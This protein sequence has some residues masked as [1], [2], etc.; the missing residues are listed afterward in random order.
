MMW[1]RIRPGAFWER[2]IENPTINH[3]LREGWRQLVRVHFFAAE[4]LASLAVIPRPV[5]LRHATDFLAASLQKRVDDLR[6]RVEF[7][8]NV[9]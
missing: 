1:G 9:E 6:P 3:A 7:V 4:I 5:S 8:Q 2:P